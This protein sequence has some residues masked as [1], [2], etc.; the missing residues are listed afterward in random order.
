MDTEVTIFK[1]ESEKIFLFNKQSW[2]HQ[3]YSFMYQSIPS[4][5]KTPDNL[6]DGRIP[7]LS[8]KKEFQT[9]GL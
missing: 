8:G 2:D 9:P 4:P 1:G 7:H 3:S 6:F 5:D